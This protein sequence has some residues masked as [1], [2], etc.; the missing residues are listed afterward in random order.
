MAEEEVYSNSYKNF[1]I[2]ENFSQ[3][4]NTDT[5]T[6]GLATHTSIQFLYNIFEQITS[7]DGSIS[8]S[9]YIETDIQNIEM[10]FMRNVAKMVSPILKKRNRRIAFIIRRFEIEESMNYPR[11]MKELHD[12]YKNGTAI[13]FHNLYFPEGHSIERLDEWFN[14]SLSTNRLK[15]FRTNY[16][17]SNWEP[18]I[19]LSK[20]DPLHD[21]DIPTRHRDHQALVY[22]LCRAGHSFYV[23]S[24]V[25]NVHRGFK[26][27]TSGH[28]AKTF[29]K[30]IPNVESASTNFIRRMNRLYPN[31]GRTCHKW[32]NNV[33]NK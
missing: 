16:K 23:L 32:N 29:L 5:F 19:V 12:M 6:L 8:L 10:I 26:K 14:Y 13:V 24:H 28:E 11:N 18:Q 7:F 9:I 22:E 15:A 3:S 2:V 17:N 31:T 20:D 27:H 25:F 21:E 1:C 33:I 4:S 30:G